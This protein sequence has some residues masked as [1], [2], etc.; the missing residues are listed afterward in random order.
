MA[1]QTDKPKLPEPTEEDVRILNERISRGRAL[2][3]EGR[4]AEA[5]PLAKDVLKLRTRFRGP[6]HWLTQASERYVRMLER[7]AALPPA[8]QAKIAESIRLESEAKNLGWQE[9]YAA[10]LP[11]L[12]RALDVRRQ[13]LG[14]DD[15]AS[16]DML[17]KAGI[18]LAHDGH[19]MEAEEFTRRAVA[20]D[21]RLHGDEDFD[22]LWTYLSLAN[23]LN[24]REQFVQS[25]ALYRF[26]LEGFRRW[27]GPQDKLVA[28]ISHNLA[29]CLFEQGES[30]AA[31]PILRHS[32]V[33]FEKP[34]ERS[35]LATAYD[36]LGK[37]LA[38][39]RKYA[40][41]ETCFRRALEVSELARG[42]N[43]LLTAGYYA[44][45]AN[46]LSA[47]SRYADAEAAARRGVKVHNERGAKDFSAARTREALAVALDGQRRFDQAEPVWRE[48]LALFRADV[49]EDHLR[50]VSASVGLALNLQAQG[51]IADA[52][53]LLESAAKHFEA[54]R[55]QVR[56]GGLERACLLAERTPWPA[57]A[58]CRLHVGKGQGAWQAF[59]ANL[60][61]GLLDEL[62]F[63]VFNPDERRRDAELANRVDRFDQQIS[64][65][66]E[67]DHLA[68]DAQEKL[69]N[70]RRQRD[71]AHS[72]MARYRAETIVKYGSDTGEAYELARIQANLPQ[73]TALVAW[74]DY[75]FE[76]KAR[77]LSE[78]H[79]ASL[80]RRTGP[81][82]WIAL[83]GSGPDGTW[84]DDDRQL[85][86]HTRDAFAADPNTPAGA[87]YESLARRLCAQRLAPLEAHLKGDGIFP[88]VRH[89]LV[90]PSAGMAGVPVE[91][92]SDQ[93]TV[94][95]AP[96]GTVCAWL[97]EKHKDHRS[98][99][100]PGTVP[101]LLALGDPV[102]QTPA[103]KQ[104][105]ANGSPEDAVAALS[106]LVL[107][108]GRS[109]AQ[110]PATRCE[111]E[112][113]GCLFSREARTELLGS[114][115]SEQRL[116]QLASSGALRSFRYLHLATHAEVDDQA[117]M[118]SALVLSQ[119]SL[120]DPVGQVLADREVMDG[121]LTAEQI[122]RTWKL[123]ADLVT[124][125][126]CQ[127]G[128]GRYGG[129]EGYVGFSQALLLA[130]ARSLVLSLWKVNDEA[131]RLLMVRFY[132]NLLG[133]RENGK[134]PLSKAEAL[135]EAKMWLRNLTPADIA[136]L[137]RGTT[138][139]RTVAPTPSTVRSFRHPHYW[140]AFILIGDPE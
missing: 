80:V 59:E 41:A 106:P 39:Q 25:E 61:R 12:R 129:G 101:K 123:D 83:P 33:Y 127:T 27:R 16:A 37:C 116:A 99:R 19:V 84:S 40:E 117:P 104:R 95:Y 76:P 77:H 23:I 63:Q 130:G 15:G 124:L 32:L 98:D 51:R 113:I 120:P 30:T 1:A 21:R 5:I 81:P 34:G 133:K 73:A 122:R 96:S 42:A 100:I 85:A 140:S 48:A 88:P 26:T 14:E 75:P 137:E 53:A 38:A 82:I 103:E 22:T 43:H 50:T 135:R 45:L 68:K 72:E 91:A 74:L 89:L 90:L 94:S 70:L 36:D 134:G 112:E 118:R 31:E 87:A 47:Q 20:I 108:R 64:I 62:R 8:D 60:A 92:L 86:K 52:E 55:P 6:S 28:Q 65:L 139:P 17:C 67:V 109:L 131:T 126:A 10:A 125:S 49:G 24:L 2:E 66:A 121:R 138:R 97:A 111:V 13:A 119:D 105:R 44:H 115:A 46:A 57:L 132:Q 3:A 18:C 78:T 136:A 71:S 9:R 11:L 7:V 56:F 58:A 110:L 128:L 69:D 114:D 93:F 4:F 102:F 29:I 35:E 107:Y 54:V 79:C